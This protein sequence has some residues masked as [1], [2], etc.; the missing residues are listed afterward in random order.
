MNS[1]LDII[2]IQ[3]K[4]SIKMLSKPTGVTFLVISKFL[5]HLLSPSFFTPPLRGSSR[6]RAPCAKADAWGD[7]SKIG[8]SPPT[9]ATSGFAL[10]LPTPPQGG[11]EIQRAPYVVFFNNPACVGRSRGGSGPYRTEPSFRGF[12]YNPVSKGIQV[13]TASASMRTAKVSA[14]APSG[15]SASTVSPASNSPASSFLLSGFMIW[16]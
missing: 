4:S 5:Y 9:G 12:F 13:F 6:S 1:I 8:K 11:S 15:W 2:E 10:V 16:V 3:D 14:S 7:D